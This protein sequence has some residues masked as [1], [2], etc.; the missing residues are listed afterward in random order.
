MET[1]D[2]IVVGGGII[3]MTTAR[4]LAMKGLS[5][6]LF[7]SGY[8]AQEASWAAGGILSSMRPWSENPVS[9]ELSNLGKTCYQRFVTEL[10]EQTDI[11][12]EYYRSGLLMINESDVEKS[13]IWASN[14][15]VAHSDSYH[16]YP[17]DMRI[18]NNSIFLP[19]IAQVRVP[20]LLKALRASLKKLNVTINENR[21]VTGLEINSGSCKSVQVGT[22][23][24]FADKFVIT[25]GTWSVQLLAAQ[26]EHIKIMPVLGQMLCVKLTEQVLDT[27]I[28][29][30]SHYLI[31]RNDGHILIGSTMEYVGFDKKTTDTARKELMDWASSLWPD[32]QN[33]KLVQHWSG[34]RPSTENNKPYLEQLL[35]HDNVYINAGHFR[36]GILQAPVCAKKITEM[37][38]G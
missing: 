27:M 8:L 36:K 32:I 37:I 22:E 14:N 10:R 29:D 28:L 30:G 34:L 23:K 9:A 4:E 18:P 38:C 33:A 16:G 26:Y 13:R 1:K 2:C 24:Y 5:V 3:G 11:D 20:R 35:D 12:P 7:D 19:D 21:P 25:A 6:S 17:D 15:H 31:P